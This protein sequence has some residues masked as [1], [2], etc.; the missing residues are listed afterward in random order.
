MTSKQRLKKF[1]LT[2]K[3][4]GYSTGMEIEDSYEKE[5]KGEKSL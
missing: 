5:R 1:L 3:M 4:H 2:R